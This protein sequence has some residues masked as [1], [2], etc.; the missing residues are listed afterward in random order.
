M[1]KKNQKKEL[2]R[3]AESMADD[4]LKAGMAEAQLKLNR[5]KEAGNVLLEGG[6]NT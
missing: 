4:G 2:R 3:N 1:N 6:W 5:G